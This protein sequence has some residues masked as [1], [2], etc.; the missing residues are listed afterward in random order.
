MPSGP[1]SDPHSAKSL[2][3]NDIASTIKLK[4]N[5]GKTK[6][7][8]N[9]PNKELISINNQ[10][11]EFVDKFTYLRSIL[12]LYGGTEEAIT[13]RLGKIRAV[14]ARMSRPIWKSNTYSQKSTE[15]TYYRPFDT[16]QSAGS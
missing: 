14:F 16:D 11:L 2:Q 3:L 6:V 5:V 8:S 10:A 9:D 4:I 13:S 1:H 15:V 7:M 12:N